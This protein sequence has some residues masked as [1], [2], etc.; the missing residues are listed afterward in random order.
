MYAI[1]V[2]QFPFTGGPD[3]CDPCDPLDPTCEGDL[4]CNADTNRCECPTG[5]V[6]I[7]D[8]CCNTYLYSFQTIILYFQEIY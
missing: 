2:Q 4:V 8:D 7:A 1:E 3:L 6:Q 5:Q